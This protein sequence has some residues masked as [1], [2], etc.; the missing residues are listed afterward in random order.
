MRP[1]TSGSPIRRSGLQE[2]VGDRLCLW[3]GIWH[4]HI[5]GGTA[6]DIRNDAA[7]A[8][9]I[10]SRGT[11]DDFSD[12]SFGSFDRIRWTFGAKREW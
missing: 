5:I 6:D 3:G 2:R 4:E 1:A 7:S 12:D 8:E 9:F 11:P 10:D